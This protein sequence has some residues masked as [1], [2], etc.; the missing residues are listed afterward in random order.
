MV[1]Y[2][3]LEQ[4]VFNQTQKMLILKNKYFFKKIS[5]QNCYGNMF[6]CHIRSF[7]VISHHM[8]FFDVI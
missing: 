2:F 6:W 4:L 8:T 3:Q 1:N 7:N 5:I